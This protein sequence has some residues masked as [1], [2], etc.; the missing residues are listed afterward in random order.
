[1]YAVSGLILDALRAPATD[2]DAVIS[3]HAQADGRCP[4]C[5]GATRQVVAARDRFGGGG[6]AIV[7]CRECGVAATHPPPPPIPAAAAW[8][9]RGRLPQIATDRILAGELRPLTDRLA[10]GATVL[11]VGSGSGARAAALVRGGYRVTALEPDPQEADAARRGLAGRA[12]VVDATVEDLDAAVGDF[13]GVLLS[14]VLEHLAD[15][16]GTLRALRGRLR[17][18]GIVVAIV[19]NA[20]GLEARLLGGRWH[21]WEPARHRWH[22]T[23]VALER[24]LVE[25]GFAGVVVRPSGG[26]R[27][28]ASLAYSLAPGLDPQVASGWR[29]AAGRFLAV[30]LAPAAGI[31]VAAGHGPQLVATARRA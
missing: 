5:G 21:G 13:D 2:E 27:Y 31:E 8:A 3:D 4:R 29:R 18:G 20:G 11:D 22:F 10:A 23:A 28:P 1:V 9:P 30:A 19:P 17:R 6:A 14:H 7:A 26:W 12:R 24:V 16:D 25:A 15:P